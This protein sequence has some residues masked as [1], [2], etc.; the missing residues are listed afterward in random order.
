MKALLESDKSIYTI[1]SKALPPVLIQ[2]RIIS[3]KK[4]IFSNIQS[5]YQTAE[6]RPPS[7]HN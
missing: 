7:Y 3:L 2:F 5:L 6:V 1:F 4:S